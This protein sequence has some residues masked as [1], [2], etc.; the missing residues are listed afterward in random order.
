MASGGTLLLDEIAEMDI[1]LQVKLLRVLNN[2]EYQPLGS[3]STLRAN[4]RIIAATNARLTDAI[5]EGR[6]REDLFFRLNVVGVELPSLRERPVDI[7]VLVE[8]FI[9]KFSCKSRRTITGISAAA[10]EVLQRYPFPGNVRELE[11]AIEHAFVM[12]HE[13][14]ILLEHL[15]ANIV[16]RGPARA[17]VRDTRSEKQII[18]ESMKRHR[19]NRSRVAEELGMHRTTLWR[20]LKMHRIAC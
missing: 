4:V 11:N 15:P 7:P 20:K 9:Q 8:H 10:L 5:E 13:P 14:T 17:P 19:G 1:A 2:G 16:E 18:E 12:C 3:N 6:F